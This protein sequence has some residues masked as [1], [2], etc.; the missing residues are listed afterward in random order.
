L[1]DSIETVGPY[2]FKKSICVLLSG[3]AGTGKTTTANFMKEYLNNLNLK[4]IIASFAKGVKQTAKFMGWDGN[5]DEKGRQLL[6]DVGM[7]G[8]A[9]NKDTWCRTTFKYIIPDMLGYPF[10]VVLID[11]CR[12]PNE[13]DYVRNDWTYQTTTVRLIAPEHECLKNTPQ[14]NDVSEVSL[15]NSRDYDYYIHNIEDL[16]SLKNKAILVVKDIIDK[17]EQ[18]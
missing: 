5:K 4:V 14:Y 2:F 10:D 9:Y 16:D 6:I 11:D 18:I 1:S 7:A 12:F 17:A 13:I 8:R 15:T 3:R